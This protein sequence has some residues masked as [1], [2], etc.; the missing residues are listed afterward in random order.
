[1]KHNY[2]KESY[3]KSLDKYSFINIVEMIELKKL[4]IEDGLS[5][6]SDFTARTIIEGIKILPKPPKKVII[7]GGGMHNCNLINRIKYFS[8]LNIKIPKALELNGNFIESE[9]IA[10]LSARVI[11]S[12]PNTFPSTTGVSKPTVGGKLILKK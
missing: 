11:N 12:L 5:T 1:M 9:L 3:P 2:F 7:I 8:N 4:K 6:L 10:F